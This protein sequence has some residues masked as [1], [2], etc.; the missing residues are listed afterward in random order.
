MTSDAPTL[1]RTYLFVPGTRPGTFRQGAG[2]RRR[3]GRARPRGCGGRGRQGR[4]AQRHRDMARDGVGRRPVAHRGAHQRRRLDLVCRRPAALRDAGVTGVLLPKAESAEQIA[5][6]QAALARCQRARAHRKRPRRGRRSTA[7]R[8]AGASRLV[9]GTLDFALDL[10]MDIAT[11]ASGLAYAASR[12]AIASRVAGL[13]APV[14]GVTPQL[15]DEARLLADLADARRF[16]FGAKLCIHPTPGAADP[17]RAASRAPRRWTGRAACWS[18]MPHRPALRGSTAAWSTGPWCCRRN[19]R[20]PWPATEPH[21][22]TSRAERDNHHGLHHHRLAHL[23]RHVQRR[24]HARR[25]VRR[26]PHRQVP[27][28]RTR[29][30]QGAGRTRHHPEGSGRRDRQELR[31]VADRLGQAQGQDR[32]D[33]LP[34]HRGGQPDQCQLP[35]QARRVLPLGRDHAG[36]H[37][38]GRRA[39]D[40]RRPGA[41]R[42]RT[43]TRSATRWP[44]WRR[45]TATRRS[46]A[47]RTCSRPRRSPSATR[48]PASWPASTA[49]ASACSSSSRAC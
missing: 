34:D 11:D 32:A 38:H 25:L 2:Q 46:S 37:R 48:W 47:A 7:S 9:F 31:A 21:S 30:R 20:W 33:R 10:D 22:P 8:A 28:H 41:G 5:A 27:R 40:A 15:D 14:A 42:S 35:R 39:A 23:R 36:H 29:T 13:P 4:G 1:A 44:R 24:A 3:R 18:P 12:I 43:W 19:A 16:G 6:T 17:R 49:I 26:E 45:S